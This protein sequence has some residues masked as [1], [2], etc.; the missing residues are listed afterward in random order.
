MPAADRLTP[1][2]LPEVR[3]RLLALQCGVCALCGERIDS[4][5][6]LDH[7]HVTGHVRGVL[8]RGCNTMLGKIESP[9]LRARTGLVSLERL[10]AMVR[11]VPGYISKRR[12]TKRHP[13]HRNEAEKRER[14]NKK[15][16]ARRAKKAATPQRKSATSHSTSQSSSGE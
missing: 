9:R 4:D 6:V 2:E 16:R 11:A 12:D 14:R 10:L 5:P 15:A 7:D 13:L 3:A 1:K 8:H